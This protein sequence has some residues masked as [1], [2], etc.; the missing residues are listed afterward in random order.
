MAPWVAV[1]EAWLVKRLLESHTFHQGVRRVHKGVHRLR[2]GPLEGD[3]GGTNIESV[4]PS[5]SHSPTPVTY[6]QQN[7]D[8]ALEVI[9]GKRFR[10]RPVFVRMRQTRCRSPTLCTSPIRYTPRSTSPTNLQKSVR[11]GHYLAAYTS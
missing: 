2:H 1:V 4:F 10:H 6:N 8:Q 9:F 11:D 3:E 5:R 7:K